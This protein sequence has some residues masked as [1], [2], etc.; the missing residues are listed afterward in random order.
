MTMVNTHEAK[1][2][3]SRLLDLAASGETV[4]LAKAGRPIAKLTRI[5]AMP[6][7]ARLGFLRGEGS[8]PDDFDDLGAEAIAELFGGATA[9]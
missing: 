6:K 3:L 7:A 9:S 1:T 4:I 2:N 5:D 8:V